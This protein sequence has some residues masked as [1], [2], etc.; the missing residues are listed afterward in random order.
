MRGS[1]VITRIV[2][3]LEHERTVKVSRLIL[4]GFSSYLAAQKLFGFSLR[5]L[6][7]GLSDKEIDLH[8]I[9]SLYYP[10]YALF[11]LA[12]AREV[13]LVLWSNKVRRI[14][15]VDSEDATPTACLCATNQ[16]IENYIKQVSQPDIIRQQFRNFHNYA[17][18][19]DLITSSMGNAIKLFFDEQ[20]L[21]KRKT[22][23]S[24]YESAWLETF[25]ESDYPTLT[26]VCQYPRRQMDVGTKIIQTL[27]QHASFAC[28]T[29]FREDKK[30]CI[31]D[32]KKD[33]AFLSDG[34]DRRKS[35]RHYI[36]IPVS[37]LG[38]CHGVVNIEF[39]K[40]E[41]FNSEDEM[42]AFYNQHLAP[43]RV[44]LE[45]QLL[46]KIFFRKLYEKWI[47]DSTS[48]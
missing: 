31:F 19:V 36:G 45:Y 22:F 24:V 9:S 39:H 33:D 17:E 16:E 44:L 12:V 28:S 25:D 4:L 42:V 7:F 48:P 37:I 23:I 32:A 41:V 46:K 6:V 38:K 1:R 13:I 20:K 5:D 43:F 29:V 26:W 40:K 30:V 2:N 21:E 15:E 3:L 18:G 11:A 10:A 35:I 47:D 27:D 34:V 8:S 14:K